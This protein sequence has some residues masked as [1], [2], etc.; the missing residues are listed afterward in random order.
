MDKLDLLF[1]PK[2]FADAFSAALR[3]SSLVA[4]ESPPDATVWI[5]GGA[6]P[7]A[8]GF[9]WDHCKLDYRG[10]RH[11]FSI[12]GL[13]I[14]EAPAVNMVAAYFSPASVSGISLR[15][16]GVTHRARRGENQ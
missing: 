10:H 8:A 14:A 1:N 12:S 2:Q 16:E 3:D 9:A 6:G 11:S 4:M 13:S 15:L 7:S 5:E